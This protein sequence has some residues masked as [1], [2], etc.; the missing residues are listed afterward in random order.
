VSDLLMPSL[1]PGENG[2]R[3]PDDRGGDEEGDGT[4]RRSIQGGAHRGYF[5]VAGFDLETSARSIL[6]HMCP[7]NFP[8]CQVPA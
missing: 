4:R 7:P 3:D 1:R 6:P 2:P 5:S 8:C